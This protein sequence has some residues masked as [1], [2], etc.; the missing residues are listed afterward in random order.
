MP[1]D[2]VAIG[3]ALAYGV[4]DGKGS[5]LVRSKLT[6][7][8]HRALQPRD[9]D[10]EPALAR[11]YSVP[12]VPAVAIEGRPDSLVVGAVPAERLVEALRADT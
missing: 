11:A 4:A 6:L 9:V 2:G 10:D 1:G 5:I 7:K 3:N 8:G 12:N